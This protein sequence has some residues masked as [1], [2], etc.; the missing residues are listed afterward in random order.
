MIEITGDDVQTE[1]LAD[2]ICSGVKAGIEGSI[3]SFRDIFNELS[4]DGWGLL[5]MDA[6]NAFNSMSRSAAI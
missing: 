4:Q 5:L 6:A 2:Q 1:Y 3:H